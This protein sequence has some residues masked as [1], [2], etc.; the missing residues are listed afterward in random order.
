MVI[1]FDV[2]GIMLDGKIGSTGMMWAQSY[3]LFCAPGKIFDQF[4]VKT[5]GGTTWYFNFFVQLM[6]DATFVA[7]QC[8]D[9]FVVN[10]HNFFVINA[11]IFVDRRFFF[12]CGGIEMLL[13][14][15][16]RER[17]KTKCGWFKTFK[18]A[19]PATNISYL[20]LAKLMHNCSNELDSKISNPKISRIPTTI[21]DSLLLPPLPWSRWTALLIF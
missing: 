14:P 6:K 9:I 15:A 21:I 18:V 2:P 8:N 1:I 3:V 7:D 16:K 10:K 5:F 12:E 4:I 13:Q 20:S 19:A 17:H 11:F